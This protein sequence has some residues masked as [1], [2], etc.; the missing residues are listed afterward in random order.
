[1]LKCPLLKKFGQWTTMGQRPGLR[2]ML[3]HNRVRQLSDNIIYTVASIQ[4]KSSLAVSV[5]SYVILI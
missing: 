4:T 3:S 5:F 1:M 2:C